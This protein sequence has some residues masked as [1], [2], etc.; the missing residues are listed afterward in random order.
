M[1]QH[2]NY[3]SP[4]KAGF[5]C[6]HCN[7]KFQLKA[8]CT[9]HIN[10]KHNGLL[11]DPPQSAEANNSSEVENSSSPSSPSPPPPSH[12][13][14]TPSHNAFD[15]AFD[16]ENDFYFSNNNTEGPPLSPLQDTPACHIPYFH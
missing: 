13:S 6:V 16:N 7:R 8:G 10:A 11:A 1:P 9:R 3:C 15:N 5:V 2:P 4:L 12:I 14:V